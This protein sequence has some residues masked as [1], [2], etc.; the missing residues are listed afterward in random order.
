MDI[1]GLLILIGAT[2][3]QAGRFRKTYPTI[4][5]LSCDERTSID[6]I[7]KAASAKKLV[8]LPSQVYCFRE[9]TGLDRDSV[10]RAVGEGEEYN[11]VA[12]QTRVTHASRWTE[13]A[14]SWV[15]EIACG[16]VRMAA[17][18]VGEMA[19][20]VG[21]VVGSGPSLDVNIAAIRSASSRV[22]IAAAD[23]AVSSLVS[24]GISPDIVCT[25]DSHPAAVKRIPSDPPGKETV[26]IHG[27]QTS[28]D[29]IRRL[30]VAGYLTYMA[31]YHTG[32]I[33]RLW[34][35][36]GV[37]PW[38]AGGN[39]GSA[40]YG[41]LA[42]LGCEQ[43][44]GVGIDCA[45]RADRTHAAS[46]GIDTGNRGVEREIPGRDGGLVPSSQAFDQYR[47]HFARSAKE[48]SHIRHVN[49]STGGARIDGWE[50]RGLD[51]L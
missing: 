5:V 25:I 1:P 44:W 10:Y 33:G 28:F 9:V 39:V 34:K 8:H 47:L 29:E 38:P 37:D 4:P 21:L 41:V 51:E 48:N 50:N 26:L 32:P 17:D 31:P 49:A 12:Y 13:H 18:L 42:K 43:I 30:R 24:A 36:L 2:E 27:P 11:A 14:G 6:E 3:D 20:K 19:S 22:T 7:R 16:R 45:F 40:C 35:K 23:T 46:T 15:V